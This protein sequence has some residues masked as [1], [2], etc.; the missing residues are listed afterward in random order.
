MTKQRLEGDLTKALKQINCYS[1]K[2]HN[3]PM[4]HQTTPA[5]YLIIT[6]N[7]NYL[8]ECKQC[9]NDS[10]A[11]SRLTQ[12]QDL[13]IFQKKYTNTFS[14][15][16]L[17][18]YTG[19][20]DKSDIYLIPVLYLNNI[21]KNHKF[22]SLNKNDAFKYFNQYKIKTEKSILQIKQYII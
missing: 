20:I 13:L 3:N 15:I 7:N 11:F 19:R 16:L 17:M 1:L 8:I 18:Y 6:R 4:A 12:L 14:Y 2:L 22:K 10:L 21:I 5:D 9:S